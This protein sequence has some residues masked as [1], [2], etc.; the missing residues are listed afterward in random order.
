MSFPHS[1]SEGI[2]HSEHVAR[3]R[4]KS[5]RSL[6]KGRESKRN[7][8]QRL[9]KFATGWEHKGQARRET[10]FLRGLMKGLNNRSNSLSQDSAAFPPSS[11]LGPVL[12]Q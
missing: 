7:S 11:V 1:W 8:S 3:Q 6:L 2:R 5:L 12:F 9:A 4:G 10:G